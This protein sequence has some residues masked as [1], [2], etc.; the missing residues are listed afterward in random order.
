MSTPS[1][2]PKFCNKCNKPRC[3]VM[4]TGQELEEKSDSNVFNLLKHHLKPV[5]LIHVAKKQLH[6]C[7]FLHFDSHVNASVFFNLY[8]ATTASLGNFEIQVQTAKQ[9]LSGNEVI[10]SQQSLSFNPPSTSTAPPLIPASTVQTPTLVPAPH[11]LDAEPSSPRP[12]TTR[13]TT[14]ID[15]STN[16]GWKRKQEESYFLL[17]ED[18]RKKR[19]KMDDLQKELAKMEEQETLMKKIL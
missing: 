3:Q 19:A 4:I 16:S 12:V 9:R 8:T 14:A 2:N 15:E 13:E 17:L 10:Y 7:G 6:R 18:I 5:G 11:S 1:V